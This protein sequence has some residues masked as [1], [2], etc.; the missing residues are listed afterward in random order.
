[1]NTLITNGTIVTESKSFL[2]DILICKGKIEAIRKK[3]KAT[4]DMQIIDASSCFVLPGGV[5]A[6]VHFDLPTPAGNSADD[7]ESGSKAAIAGGT[8]TIIDFVTP[9][10]GE[11]FITALQKRKKVAAKSHIDYS[12]HM[13]VTWWGTQSEQEIEQC[14][15]KEE[16]TSFKV[17]LAYKGAVGID[18]AEL[19]ETMYAVKKYN[20]LL[21]VHCEHGDMIKKLQ[22][23]FIAAGKTS[24]RFHPLSRPSAL[25][26]EAVYK[27]LCFAKIIG[28]RIYIVHVSSAKSM[29]LIKAARM[30]GQEV[31]VETCPHYLLL[32]ENVYKKPAKQALKYVLSPPLRT[33][34]DNEQ[35][36][37]ELKNGNIDVL[38]TD[39]CPFHTVAQK[40]IGINDFSKIPNGGNGV[41]ERLR[42]LFTYGVK[43]NIISMNQMV[44]LT[45]T[46]PAKIFGIYP[47]KGSL[48]IG[49][50]ADIIIW[51]PESKSTI[52]AKTHHQNG[53]SNI[54]EGFR[55]QGS[56]EV[57]LAK[58]KIIFDKGEFFLKGVKG[59]LLKKIEDLK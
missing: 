35:L 7:F 29:E 17:Y 11:S 42:L 14:I 49:S 41:E 2:S 52:S 38:A 40:D 8:T 45:S 46:M 36:W 33:K 15:K 30:A 3:I 5:D 51:N 53:D 56:P 31:F 28:C 22:K 23:E 59:E 20:G 26:A 4:T 39:H 55:V 9:G 1:M 57:V 32:N 24:P 16:I 58:G 43:K 37:D 19:I 21:T 48:S 13:G 50:D 34:F 18:D 47:Q 10:K 25:E 6:H 27:V 54:Y 12:F 44:K